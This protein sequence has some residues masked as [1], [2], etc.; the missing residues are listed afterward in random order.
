MACQWL[1]VASLVFAFFVTTYG[2]FHGSDSKKP[3]G[4]A[5]FVGT[6]VAV[7]LMALVQFGAGSFTMLLGR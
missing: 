7:V 6:C 5:G 2:D 1:I 3:H 4:F